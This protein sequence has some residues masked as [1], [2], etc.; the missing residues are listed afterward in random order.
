MKH[1]VPAARV[2]LAVIRMTGGGAPSTR[3]LTS[4]LP[5]GP[6]VLR[7]LAGPCWSPPHDPRSAIRWSLSR[8]AYSSASRPSLISSGS[9]SRTSIASRRLRGP[10]SAIGRLPSRYDPAGSPCRA[11]DR[12]IPSLRH[13]PSL[14]ALRG[15]AAAGALEVDAEGITTP[16]APTPVYGLYWM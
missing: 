16:A 10:G 5:D 9:S 1:T 7:L 12:N 15:E 2:A 3:V 6:I 11:H 4:S 14:S 8:S 13:P